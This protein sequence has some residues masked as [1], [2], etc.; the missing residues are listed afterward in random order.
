M[1]QVGDGPLPP[2]DLLAVLDPDP[3]RAEAR[4]GEL[5]SQLVR[6]FEWQR[7]SDPEDAAQE[8][9]ARGFRRVAAGVDTSAAGVHGYFFGIARNL[10][11]EGWKGRREELLDPDA[12]ERTPSPGRHVEQVEA[13]LA[14]TYYLGRLRASERRLIVRYYTGDRDALS[15]ELGVTAGNLRVIVHRIRQKIEERRKTRTV[16]PGGD[17]RWNETK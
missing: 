1:S 4:Y 10:V 17:A 2:T 12:W 14:L 5:R 11:K 8:T 13:R 16:A 7:H 15:R 9:L 6:F 3:V